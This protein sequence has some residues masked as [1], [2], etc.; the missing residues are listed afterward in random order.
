[1][2]AIAKAIGMLGMAYLAVRYDSSPCG[3]AACI[4]LICLVAEQ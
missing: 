1:M 4:L 3:V 2:K